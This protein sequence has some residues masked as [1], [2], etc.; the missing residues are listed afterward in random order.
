MV[1]VSLACLPFRKSLDF[2]DRIGF[3][4]IL[5]RFREVKWSVIIDGIR[6]LSKGKYDGSSVDL[7]EPELR[8][9]M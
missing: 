7:I 2:V 8:T 3:G 5:W 6:D 4:T 1:S 9:E